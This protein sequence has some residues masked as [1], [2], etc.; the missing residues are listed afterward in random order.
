VDDSLRFLICLI[1]LMATVLDTLQKGTDYLVRHG[2]E[3]AR[4]N[5]Q[6][7]LAHALKCDRM[8]LYLDFDRELD[9]P[10]LER[11]RDLVKRRG[12]GDPLQHLLGTVEFLG[13]EFNTD[14]R[15]LIPRPETEELC[16]RLMR[17]AGWPQGLRLLDVGTGS[18]VIGLTLLDRWQSVGATGVLA[19]LSPDALELAR[20]NAALLGLGP[21]VVEFVRSDLFSGLGEP[22]LSERFDLIVANL[23]YIPASEITDLSREV[24]KDP[25]MAL[26]GGEVGTEI[27]E[28]LLL[29]CGPWLRPGGVVALEYGIGQG[30]ALQS[31]AESAG[32]DSIQ[33][34]KDLTGTERFL[35]AVKPTES[36]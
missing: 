25:E 35:F 26:L 36:A 12:K 29:A 13:R 23:P 8:Q 15:A 18:G 32:L 11:L 3:E 6:L 33:L 14:A 17:R 22:A 21:P 16:D 27:M 19:D 9:E 7:M 2:I 28:R 31:M 34:V 4:L 10:V 30:P 24:R 1:F 5:M 20:E